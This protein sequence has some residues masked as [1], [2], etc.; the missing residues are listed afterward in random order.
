MSD[1]GFQIRRQVDDV[2]RTKWAFLHAN[3]TPNTEPLRN[4]RDSRVWCDF[5]TKFA[6]SYNGA[7]FL[8]F[9]TTF[10]KIPPR[11]SRVTEKE[12]Y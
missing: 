3:T 5:N 4:E 1:L 7:G 11:Q 8:A 2:D 9:L 6:S 12:V 10:L